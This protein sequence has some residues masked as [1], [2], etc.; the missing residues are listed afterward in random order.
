MPGA[1][2]DHDPRA[3]VWDRLRR[4]ARPDSRLHYDFAHMHPDF[5][6]SDLAARRLLDEGLAT[7]PRLAFVVPDG[8]A[9]AAR[10]SLLA[11][12]CRLVVSTF[13]MRRGFRLLDPAAIDPRDFAFA[14]TLDGVER[15]GRDIAIA[16]IADLGQ[17]DLVLTGAAAVSANGARFGRS[18]QYFD[19]EWGLLA[20]LG[21]ARERTP[22]A[23]IVHDVQVTP[24]R[25]AP[26]PREAVPDLIATPSRLIRVEGRPRRPT[27]VHW[28]GI[29]PEDLEQM[30]ALVDLLRA[31]GER[32]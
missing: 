10:E 7:P 19:I 25:V 24:D 18:Y 3:G 15:F 12:G 30:P 8:A 27:A 17:M 14:A 9:Q 11:R 32:R 26:M 16:G 13:C 23:V 22:V 20:E 29:D 2:S 1:P 6:G 21:V 28:A 31:R 5:E 4:V